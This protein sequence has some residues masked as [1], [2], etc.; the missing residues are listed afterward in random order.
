MLS[1]R[2]GFNMPVDTKDDV[3]LVV[4]TLS[5]IDTNALK[6][7]AISNLQQQRV[8][9][10][11]AEWKLEKSKWSP[12]IQFG[13]FNQSIDKLSPFWGYSLGTSIPLFKT[14][15]SGRVNAAKLQSKIAQAE[16]DNF[17]I[18]LNTAYTLA[19]QEYELN[20][21]KLKYYNS[22]GLQ[23]ASI[24]M[25]VADKSYKAG[26]IS[27]VEFIQSISKAYEIQSSYLQTVNNYN[28]SAINLNYLISK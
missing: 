15:Q 1:N 21:E 13:A 17:N 7:N 24:L 3:L 26:D 28:Q 4:A 23:V 14:G 27:Y 18:S 12:S 19:L 25:T 9:L 8:N 2:T 6:Q 16:F 5:Q 22:E 11:I 10:S 20:K